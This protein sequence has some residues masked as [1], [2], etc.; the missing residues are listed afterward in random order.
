MFYTPLSSVFAIFFYFSP[1]FRYQPNKYIY[2]IVEY[3]TS[4][5]NVFQW[6]VLPFVGLHDFFFLIYKI[7]DLDIFS[8]PH[9]QW[10]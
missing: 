3:I 6:V 5:A 1:L 10:F 9:S 8:S 2:L 4:F 7:D